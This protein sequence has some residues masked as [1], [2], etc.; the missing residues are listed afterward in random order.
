MLQ[1]RAVSA[2]AAR[3]LLQQPQALTSSAST[4]AA[5][6]RA[7]RASTGMFSCGRHV[8]SVPSLSRLKCLLNTSRI[9]LTRVSAASC[10]GSRAVHRVVGQQT[11][12]CL[13]QAS[14]ALKHRRTQH[15]H[16]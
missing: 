4:R 1:Q 15:R 2:G 11:A 13:S 12:V 9:L 3:L 16:V 14:S 10:A 5:S 8:R 6:R 7:A